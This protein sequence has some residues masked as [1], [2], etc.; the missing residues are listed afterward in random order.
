MVIASRTGHATILFLAGLIFQLQLI[1]DVGQRLAN[2]VN[3]YRG[4][5]GCDD[6]EER[7][8]RQ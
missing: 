1:S 4:W 2:N 5:H 8:R 3:R 6:Q 7:I